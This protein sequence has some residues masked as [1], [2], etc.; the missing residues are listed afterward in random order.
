MLRLDISKARQ[1]LGWRPTWD[2]ERALERTVEWYR[3]YAK[4]ADVKALTAA[5]IA[6]FEVQSK[7]LE[8]A[9]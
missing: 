1:K 6:D 9:T 2:V 3:S 5:Q 7:L 8:Q 4:G